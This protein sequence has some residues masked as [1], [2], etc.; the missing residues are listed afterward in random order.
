MPPSLRDITDGRRRGAGCHARP[1]ALL[2]SGPTGAAFLT[3]LG[4]PSRVSRPYSAIS[5]REAADHPKRRRRAV[6]AAGA[7]VH[8]GGCAQPG[9]QSA[10]GH[11]GKRNV[12]FLYA[13]I[14]LKTVVGVGGFYKS[15]IDGSA[16]NIVCGL[17]AR[18]NP[19]GM[20]L[21]FLSD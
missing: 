2:G 7:V 11:V 6:R 3:A 13:A 9:F 12:G 19:A 18:V 5:G 21:E 8:I 15:G 20:V 14:P 17:R 1:R 16:L 10:R 4:V